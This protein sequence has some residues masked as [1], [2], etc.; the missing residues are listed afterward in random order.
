[1]QRFTE[2][3]EKIRREEE[4]RRREKDICQR[5]LSNLQEQKNNKMK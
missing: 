2:D 3:A 5:T 4:Q 1:V